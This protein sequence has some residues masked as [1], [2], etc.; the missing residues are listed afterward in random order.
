MEWGVGGGRVGGV[1]GD[2]LRPGGASEASD[3]T[4]YFGLG[5]ALRLGLRY[6]RGRGQAPINILSISLASA[7]YAYILLL[8]AVRGL[9]T[10]LDGG[11]LLE[12][13]RYWLLSVAVVVAAVSTA[14]VMLISV[15][16]RYREIGVLKCLGALDGH[17]LMLLLVEALLQGVL[18]GLLGL[19]MGVLASLL[20]LPLREV[21]SLPLPSYL[22][23]ATTLLLSTLI[24]VSSSLY[25]AYRAMRLNPIEALR[26]EV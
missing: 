18:G 2:Q 13:Y 7:F 16:E 4:T 19:S 11:S 23:L 25:P 10:P 3:G 20:S 24:A 17:V 1:G 6:I 8:N 12:T 9:Q 5:D 15:Y 14:T 22:G 21:A 26:Y